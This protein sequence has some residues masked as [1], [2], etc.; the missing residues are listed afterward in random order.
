MTR[1]AKRALSSDNAPSLNDNPAT[2]TGNIGQPSACAN[3]EEEDEGEGDMITMG[4]SCAR[5]KQ[6]Q[7]SAAMADERPAKRLKQTTLVKDTGKPTLRPKTYSDLPGKGWE[8]R[9]GDLAVFR[10]SEL[11]I[12]A[13]QMSSFS[14]RI[15]NYRKSENQPVTCQHIDSKFHRNHCLLHHVDQ[16][17]T[18]SPYTSHKDYE[19][20]QSQLPIQKRGWMINKLY[21]YQY[22]K[23]IYLQCKTNAL[24]KSSTKE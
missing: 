20:S 6:A 18:I 4:H 1:A 17:F 7:A 22:F 21:H 12:N 13:S 2:L 24:S 9:K 19:S 11:G 8:L 23:H 16:P 14:H 15:I 10:S 3:E 5:N